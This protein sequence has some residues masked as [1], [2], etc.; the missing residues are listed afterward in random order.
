M[1]NVLWFNEALST[2]MAIYYIGIGRL[3]LKVIEFVC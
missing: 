1:V 3:R 2:I